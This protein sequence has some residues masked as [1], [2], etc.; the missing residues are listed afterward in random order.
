[1][2][3]LAKGS[4]F[5]TKSALA[6]GDWELEVFCIVLLECLLP[7]GSVERLWK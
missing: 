4:A 1:M 5:S 6:T 7:D 2:A 3:R